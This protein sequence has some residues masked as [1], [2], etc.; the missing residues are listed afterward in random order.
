MDV[1]PVLDLLNGVVVRGVGGKRETYRPIESRICPSS[2]PLAVARAFRDQFGLE[3]LYVADLDAI[4]EHRPNLDVY[5]RLT[6][7]GFTLLVDAG[8]RYPEEAANVLQTG[9]QAVIAGLESIP[10]ADLLST[11][12]SEL[13]SQ[14]VIFSLDLQ[15]GRPLSGNAAW[16]GMTPLNI[17][18]AAIRQGVKRLIVLDLGQVGIGEGIS[19]LELCASIRSQHPHVELITGGGVRHRSDLQLLANSHVDGVLIASALHNG[20]LSRGDLQDLLY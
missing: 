6:Q 17:A 13:G 8:I 7:E 3:R 5:R 9:A 20:Q 4:L 18:D 10:Q 1:L 11:L 14:R 2:E 19:T 15:H 12:V 16:L